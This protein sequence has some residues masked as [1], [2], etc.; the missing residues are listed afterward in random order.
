MT[1]PFTEQQLQQ[2]G[3]II[4]IIS[5]V[6]PVAVAF[7]IG[8]RT[9][10][11]LG[12][13][14]KMLPHV[15]GVI[16]SITSVLLILGLV[17]IKQ[18][19]KRLHKTTM[20]SAFSLGALFLVTYILY[21][22]SNKETPFGGDGAVKIIYYFFLITH[23]VLSIVVVRLVLLALNFALTSQFERHK[24]MVRWAYPIWLYVSVT[25]VVVYLMISPYYS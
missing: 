20:L 21:H 13:W 5:I 19:N 8:I 10:L 17:F 9:K 18:K 16:N 24:K 22:I 25:G 2:R 6:I 23:I 15:N 1:T 4:N 12:E 11:P 14:T 3:K 7:L